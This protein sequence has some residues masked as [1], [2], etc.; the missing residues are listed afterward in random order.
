MLAWENSGFSVDASVRITLLDRDVPSSSTGWPIS[1]RRH[2]AGHRQR[3]SCRP[4]RNPKSQIRNPKQIQ[5][6]KS[7]CPK[8]RRIDVIV[9]F[10]A[11][12]G[13]SN[14]GICFG[15]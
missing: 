12:L 7:K 10:V 14:F 3:S 4:Q 2:G 11:S 5:N 13:Y 15:S 9:A 1:S 8:P 6:P